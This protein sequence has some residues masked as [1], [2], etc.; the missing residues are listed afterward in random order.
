MAKDLPYF[1]FYSS[2]WNDGDI[3]LED[4][5]TQGLFINIC[6]YYWSQECQVSHKKLQKR[7]KNHCKQLHILFLSEIIHEDGDD[8][9]IKFLD[10][11]YEER[12]VVKHRNKANGLKGGRPKKTQ[13]VNSGLQVA[14]PNIS[15]GEEKREE[16][17]REDIK[18]KPKKDARDLETFDIFRKAYLGTKNGNET[19]FTNFQKKHKDWKTI[20]P[21]L[22]ALLDCII[23]QREALKSSGEFVPQWKNLSTWINQRC[24]E[25]EIGQESPKKKFDPMDMLR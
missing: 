16:E 20:L 17:K 21:D 2:E 1:K 14:N 8:I 18:S 6:S 10:K 25:E 11:Q 12:E 9:K 3:T 23:N 19:E 15:Q 24:W 4:M 22:S 7:F 13:S 5:K